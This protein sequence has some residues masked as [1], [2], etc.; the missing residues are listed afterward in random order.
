MPINCNYS[1]SLQGINQAQQIM[2]KSAQQVA[3]GKGEL[4]KEAASQIIAQDSLSANVKA[5]K[6]KDEMLKELLNM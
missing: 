6:S 3:E 4:E 5:I 2:N 1:T